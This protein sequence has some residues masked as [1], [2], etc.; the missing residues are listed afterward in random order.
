VVVKLKL[1]NND[2]PLCLSACLY[3]NHIPVSSVHAACMA[4]H[5]MTKYE[6]LTCIISF[7]ACIVSCLCNQYKKVCWSSV[8]TSYCKDLIIVSV[9]NWDKDSIFEV[10]FVSWTQ[11]SKVCISRTMW[12][13]FL[14]LRS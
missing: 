3:Q 4:N 2:I 11:Y 1:K 8:M 5:K 7:V 6:Y 12:C 10:F 14:H 13:I 9:L